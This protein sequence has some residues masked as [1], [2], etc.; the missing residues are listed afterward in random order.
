MAEQL[1]IFQ[2]IAQLAQLQERLTPVLPA[3]SQKLITDQLASGTDARKLA[4][5]IGRKPGFIRQVESGSAGL[6]ATQ[7]VKV[8]RHVAASE[9]AANAS[10]D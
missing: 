1:N 2:M 8:L 5:V 4:K 10:S 6:T 7:I 9:K 3:I